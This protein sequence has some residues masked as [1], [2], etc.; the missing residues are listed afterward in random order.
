MYGINGQAVI[1]LDPFI[2]VA[3][4]NAL[5]EEC[6][7]GMARSQ[8]EISS[9]GPGVYDKVLAR[10]LFAIEM[11]I[12]QP[13]GPGRPAHPDADYLRT[14]LK[15]MTPNQRR[16][17]LKLR[18]GVYSSGQSVYLRRSLTNDYKLIN[19]PNA[20][21][22]TACAAHFPNLVGWIKALP[23]AELGRILFFINE[24]LCPVVEHSDLHASLKPRGYV[25]NQPHGYE[26][27]WIRPKADSSKSFY[28]LDESTQ[29]RHYVKGS[30]AWFNSFDVH[31]ADPGP[32][33]T[34]S[35]RVDGVFTPAL[36]K[37]LTG[38]EL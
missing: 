22:W 21:K 23:F 34:W 7:L 12:Y 19:Q 11:G 8:W 33:M 32:T 35:L 38:R 25:A 17:Y 2:D 24:H 13:A 18:Y 29:E 37:A 30:A 10:D 3:G 31:G 15:N 14:V 5:V 6:H 16:T 1:D 26:F 20:N 27:L 28:V 36:R 4:F 9:F